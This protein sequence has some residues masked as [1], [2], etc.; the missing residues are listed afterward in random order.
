MVIRQAERQHQARRELAVR[1]HGFHAAARHAEDG[2]FGGVENGREAGAANAAQ[3]GDGKRA[4]LHFFQAGLAGAGAF[5]ELSQ[6][7]REG[8]D[9]L[10]VHVADDG[11]QQAA[12]GVHRHADVIVLLVDDFMGRHVDTGVELREP[13]E[14]GGHHFQ[15]NGRD[16]EPAARGNGFGGVL[17]PQVLEL[18][19]VGLIVLR[20][21]WNGGPGA[22]HLIGG[23]APHVAHGSPLDLAP[24]TEIRQGH[25]SRRSCRRGC[26][27]LI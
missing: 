26:T 19:D 17:P 21:L 24:A 20:H 11:N 18:G 4:A 23:K 22:R 10:A 16:G 8:D 3:V 14:S 12:V 25:G 9:V 2:H 15:R 13:F 7:D 1:V 5:G 6:L 27:G